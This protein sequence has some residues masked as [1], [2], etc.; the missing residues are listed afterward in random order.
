[1]KN[2]EDNLKD[3]QDTTKPTNT[4]IIG[5]TEEK[6]REKAKSLFEKIKAENYPNLGKEIRHSN[7]GN[8]KTPVKMALKRVTS[9]TL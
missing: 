2:N 8:P 3:L 4:Y 9:G 6:R 5:V 7:P 1:M